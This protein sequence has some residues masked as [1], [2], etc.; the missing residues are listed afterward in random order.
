ML[1]A[2]A[3]PRRLVGAGV[4]FRR[5]AYSAGE[6]APG[7]GFVLVSSAERWQ[8]MQTAAPT[9]YEVLGVSEFATPS[10]IRGAYLALAKTVHPDAGG[11]DSAFQRVEEAAYVLSDPRRKAE[12][13]RHLHEFGRQVSSDMPGATGSSTQRGSPRP[14]A[15]APS[16]HVEPETSP[17]RIP[18]EPLTF[19]GIL[20]QWKNPTVAAFAILLLGF[21]AYRTGVSAFVVHAHPGQ[22][23]LFGF[24]WYPNPVK[25][26]GHGDIVLSAVKLAAVV[27]VAWIASGVFGRLWV[28]RERQGHFG[29]H[30]RKV[31]IVGFLVLAVV[32]PFGLAGSGTTLLGL[33]LLIWAGIAAHR[34]RL[35]VRGGSGVRQR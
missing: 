35:G 2:A 9:Y 22:E 31:I 6:W 25:F 15:N 18:D 7:K 17:F 27:V 26:G 32:G 30:E 29:R 4:P 12:Y 24:R 13:D 34:A 16:S 5:L 3:A 10:E 1:A 33:G 19:L 11:S 14:G 23:V 20:R 28:W 8:V 21:A